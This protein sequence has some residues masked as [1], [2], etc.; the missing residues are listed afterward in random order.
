MIGFGL[1]VVVAI[2]LAIL[3]CLMWW[4][5]LFDDNGK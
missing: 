5:M 4:A 2:V 1:L 3:V